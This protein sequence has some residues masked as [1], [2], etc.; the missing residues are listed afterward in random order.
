MAVRMHFQMIFMLF[1][2]SVCNFIQMN[3][4]Y[5]LYYYSNF[6][7]FVWLDLYYNLCVIYNLQ[8]TVTVKIVHIKTRGKYESKF[9]MF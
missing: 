6:D 1:A 4:H 5:L 8:N 9:H 7:I 2:T 3:V